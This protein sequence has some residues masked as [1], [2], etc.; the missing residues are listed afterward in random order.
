MKFVD[1]LEGANAIA[2]AFAIC[3][4]VL[5]VAIL[6]LPLVLT[7]VFYRL[8]YNRFMVIGTLREFYYFLRRM[9]C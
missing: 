6:S 9:K 5:M 3:I 7:Y 1:F 4:I 2:M 8:A